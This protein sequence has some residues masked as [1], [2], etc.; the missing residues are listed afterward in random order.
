MAN[1]AARLA[2]QIK[3]P[4]VSLPMLP[5]ANPADNATALPDDDPIGDPPR[6][7]AEVHCP[8]TALHPDGTDPMNADSSERLVLPR[9]IAPFALSFFMTVASPGTT[10]STSAY[11][12]AVVCIPRREDV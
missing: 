8:P 2:G 1:K 11:V 10:E 9:M 6:T 7:Y 4:L 12:P 5:A 3:D